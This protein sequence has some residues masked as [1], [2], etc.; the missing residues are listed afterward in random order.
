MKLMDI[1]NPN[2]TPDSEFEY[3]E[4]RIREAEAVEYP[5]EMPEGCDPR[6]TKITFA[7]D[8]GYYYVKLATYVLHMSENDALAELCR[9]SLVQFDS[10]QEMRNFFRNIRLSTALERVQTKMPQTERENLNL[11]RNE[12]VQR[13]NPQQLFEDMTE[14]IR[15][16]DEAVRCIVRYACASAAKRNP[17]RPPSIVLVGETGQGKTLAGKTLAQAINCQ[18]TDPNQQYGTIV[19]HCN[20]LTENHDVSRLI[21]GSPNYVGYGDEN[22]LSPLISNPYQVIVFDEIEKAAPRVLDVLMG[23]LDSGEIMMSK[24][25]DGKNMLD[26][27]RCDADA[28]VAHRNGDVSSVGGAHGHVYISCARGKVEG[29]GEQMV[30]HLAYIRWHKIGHDA[31]F[32][33]CK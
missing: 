21:G 18:I 13:L 15:G 6:N 5:I 30:H 31:A 24:P 4:N 8:R 29:V 2:C 19:V 7:Y 33:R 26:F 1:A 3:L 10:A 28:V 17:Q 14:T 9:G 25:I 11:R 12:P 23:A 20:E 32:R 22:V 27:R 16:Q